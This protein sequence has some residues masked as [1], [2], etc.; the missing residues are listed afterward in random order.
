MKKI[1]STIALATSIG[2][3]FAGC[4]AGAS[5]FS[6]AGDQHREDRRAGHGASARCGRGVLC[7]LCLGVPPVQGHRYLHG[8]AQ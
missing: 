1:I 2:A 3:V 4:G 7:P 5:E 8:R 6:G